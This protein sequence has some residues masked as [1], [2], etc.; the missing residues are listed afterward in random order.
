MKKVSYLFIV[1]A[2]LLSDMMC[3]VVAYNY[4]TLQWGG[5]YA[6]YSAPASTA[7]LYVIP[8][9]IGIIFCI[10]LACVFHKKQENKK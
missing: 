5:Q 9:W 8:Y 1:L 2:I 4:C 3:A 7:F 10:I 6:G